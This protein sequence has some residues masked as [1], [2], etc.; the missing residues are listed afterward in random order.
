MGQSETEI[1]SRSSSSSNYGSIRENRYNLAEATNSEAEVRVT[2]S[3]ETSYGHQRSL[4]CWI[5]LAA[6]LIALAHGLHDVIITNLLIEKV[7]RVDLSLG[8]EICDDIS[9]HQSEQNM[10]Q[11]RVNDL[12]LYKVILTSVPWSVGTFFSFYKFHLFSCSILISLVVGPYSDKY[13]RRPLLLIPLLGLI[14]SQI[15]YL[16]NVYYWVRMARSISTD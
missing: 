5:E 14:V 2:E 8:S 15:I 6:F 13:G 4:W 12:N 3:S 10:V 16:V 11:E 7:C 1:I 9:N